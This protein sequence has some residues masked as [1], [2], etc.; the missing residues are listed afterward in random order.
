VTTNLTELD[1]RA[2]RFYE[3][4]TQTGVPVSVKQQ[5]ILQVAIEKDLK[6]LLDRIEEKE[7]FRPNP[8]SAKDFQELAQYHGHSLPRTKTGRP[9]TSTWTIKKFEYYVPSL[10]TLADARCLSKRL[11]T[12]QSIQKNTKEGWVHPTYHFDKELGRVHQGGTVKCDNWST[13]C[14]RFVCLEEHLIWAADYDRMEL[15]IL[16]RLSG[17]KQLQQD[18][19]GDLYIEFA[20]YLY[21][22]AKISP[23]QR[24]KVKT[25]KLAMIYGNTIG[26]IASQMGVQTWEAR[27]FK[28]KWGLRYPYAKAFLEDEAKKAERDGELT[29]FFGRVKKVDASKGKAY[30]RRIGFNSCIQNTAGDLAKWGFVNLA[31]NPRV[32][33]LDVQILTTVH[34]AVIMAVPKKVYKDDTLRRELLR[35]IEQSLVEG[36]D[37]SFK[38]SVTVKSSETWDDESYD[39]FQLKPQRLN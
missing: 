7:H 33:E 14:K 13:D 18:L 9:D 16:A 3:K 28:K 22:T 10:R 27:A 39:E 30:V 19:E 17:D 36:I 6:E 20:K 25:G 32:K 35:L 37:Q 38:L 29:S 1:E 26:G 34:D 12:V 23:I 15:A 5:G 31:E 4:L 24:S 8:N 2:H 11:S 21:K